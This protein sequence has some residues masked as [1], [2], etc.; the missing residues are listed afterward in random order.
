MERGVL[1]R[2]RPEARPACLRKRRDGVDRVQRRDGGEREPVELIGGA[3]RERRRFADAGRHQC[4]SCRSE[5]CRPIR[6][7]AEPIVEFRH[8]VRQVD[9]VRVRGRLGQHRDLE[10][11]RARPR[12]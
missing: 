4:P 12:T 6:P 8:D 10:P 11:G 2:Q 3:L 9:D 7:D 5:R 1:P